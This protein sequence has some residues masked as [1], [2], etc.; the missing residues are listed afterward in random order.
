MLRIDYVYLFFGISELNY[1]LKTFCCTHAVAI[2]AHV[3]E[4]HD[5]VVLLNF[6][7]NLL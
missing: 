3:A 1:L 2:V 6:I 7:K 4:Q 5:A